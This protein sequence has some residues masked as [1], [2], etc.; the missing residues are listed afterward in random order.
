MPE[1]TPAAVADIFCARLPLELHAVRTVIERKIDVPE[2]RVAVTRLQAAASKGSDAAA[3]LLDCVYLTI[4]AVRL[5]RNA[6]ESC[7][8]RPTATIA[9][10]SRAF[11]P[12]WMRR[13]RSRKRTATC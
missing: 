5:F 1:L 10:S 13:R 11:A 8:V 3:A 12:T 7:P 4:A 2:A 9:K 6:S